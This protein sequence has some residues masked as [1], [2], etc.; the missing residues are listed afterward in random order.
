MWTCEPEYWSPPLDTQALL[1][2]L[3]ELT[4]AHEVCI[5]RT[6]ELISAL[7]A[8]DVT[9]MRAAVAAQSASLHSIDQ[10]E[11]RRRLA[12]RGL[13]Y[14]LSAAV[15][16]SR[17]RPLMQ[18]S[19][20]TFTMLLRSLPPE[21]AV[22]LIEARHSLL[23]TVLRLQSLQRRAM[24]LAQTGQ[25]VVQRTLRAAFGAS[26]EGYGTAG[27]QALPPRVLAFRQGRSA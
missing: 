17:P 12:V 21:Y 8:A 26:S 9:R 13:A 18:D 25:I 1:Q 3:Q 23:A 27:E 19:S 14:S 15:D 2:S 16:R 10:A 6:E 22:P 24:A 20:M 5:G 7:A 11:M 4:A